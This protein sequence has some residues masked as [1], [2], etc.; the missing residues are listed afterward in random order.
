MF[1]VTGPG[2][3]PSP[4]VNVSP[5]RLQEMFC[6]V[7][8]S[9][10]AINLKRLLPSNNPGRQDQVGK[11][12][13]VIGVEM[14]EKSDPE[15]YCFQPSDSSLASSRSLPDDSGAKINEIRSTVND[16]ACRRAGALRIRRGGSSTKEND[17]RFLGWSAL[18]RQNAMPDEKKQ[19]RQSQ[20]STF[21]PFCSHS[22][23]VHG[24]EL[25]QQLCLL[26]FYMS[27]TGAPVR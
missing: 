17:L 27:Q 2:F 19:N 4:Y 26:A 14:S 5:V 25:N 8:C 1:D 15:V 9:W 18:R 16:D 3:N 6:H 20:G 24:V 11:A 12:Q 23:L 13:S 22:A 10:W 7:A 21:F